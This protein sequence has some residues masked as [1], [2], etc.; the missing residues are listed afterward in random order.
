MNGGYE[1]D[2]CMFAPGAAELIADKNLE[3]LNEMFEE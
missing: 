2:N 1:A 3:M